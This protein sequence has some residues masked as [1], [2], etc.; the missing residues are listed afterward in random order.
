MFALSSSTR[1][2]LVVLAALVLAALLL[3][4]GDS[5]GW[6]D[7]PKR[8]AGDLLAPAGRELT[9]LGEQAGARDPG[10]DPNLRRQ[11]EDVTAERDRLLA[12]NAQLKELSSEVE[13]LRQQLKFQE[14]RPDLTYVTAD[15]VSRDPQSREKYVVINRGSDDGVQVG[16]AVVSPNFLVGQVVEVEA[17]RSKVLLVIDS[18]FQTGG[19]LQTARAEGVVYGLWQEGGR[20]EMRHIPY[21]VNI[22]DKEVVVTSGKTAGIPEG[23]VVGKVMEIRKDQAQNETVV[24]VL[25][26]VNFDNL[27]SVTVITGTTAGQPAEQ[28]TPGT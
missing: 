6:L 14:S 8:L 11:L 4:L 20:V 28:A 10:G 18:G 19:R 12:E 21:D 1:R 15:V 9:S 13:S 17:N 7:T 5:R 2:N 22:D 26:L 3:I 27:E 25:P 24:E 23:L 16:M